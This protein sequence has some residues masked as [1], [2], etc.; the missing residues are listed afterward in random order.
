MSENK[1]ENTLKQTFKS[2]KKK[3]GSSKNFYYCQNNNNFILLELKQ[4]ENYDNQVDNIIQIYN[5]YTWLSN[6]PIVMFKHD[7]TMYFIYIKC[8]IIQEYYKNKNKNNTN[9]NNSNNFNNSNDYSNNS[10]NNYTNND[11]N[12]NH[13]HN[14]NHDNNSHNNNT[15]HN[16]NDNLHNKMVEMY[17]DALIE[18]LFLNQS[19]HTYF[20]IKDINI[21]I[22]CGINDCKNINSLIDL[23]SIDS[24]V[25]TWTYFKSYNHQSEDI[26]KKQS[27]VI[28]DGIVKEKT[29]KNKQIVNLLHYFRYFTYDLL[30]VL[31]LI[32]RGIKDD[33]FTDKVKK[34]T[35]A[36]DMDDD[37][38]ENNHNN[39]INFGPTN[40]NNSKHSNSNNSKHSNSNNSKHSNSNNSKHKYDIYDEYNA[41][42]NKSKEYI[43]ISKVNGKKNN[44][45]DYMLNFF[46]GMNNKNNSYF[47]NDPYNDKDSYK[48]SNHK[49]N[50]Y[51]YE[52]ENKSNNK[53]TYNSKKNE[54]NDEQQNYEV[55]KENLFDMF[56]SYCIEHYSR[57]NKNS[58][59]YIANTTKLNLNN[60]IEYHWLNLII[61]FKEKLQSVLKQMNNNKSMTLYNVFDNLYNF[62]IKKIDIETQISNICN[63]I[64]DYHIKN[65]SD[66]KNINFIKN[67][68]ETIEKISI[69]GVDNMI[70]EKEESQLFECYTILKLYK[71]FMYEVNTCNNNNMNCYFVNDDPNDNKIVC[72][73]KSDDVVYTNDK[74]NKQYLDNTNVSNM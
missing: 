10:Y 58:H 18:I 50:K 67:N 12:T 70:S 49:S 19:N 64:Y 35:N 32:G 74:N 56:Y 3:D 41:S 25:Y 23:D 55:I 16:N 40:K 6:R 17:C 4:G 39:Y 65:N 47:I 28:N 63:I 52:E 43:K 71:Y 20:D 73:N 46:G 44:A 38:F 68:I 51:V 1:Q 2:N 29:L 62:L 11:T 24:Y 31:E 21:G 9:S 8:N 34:N 54:S 57:N 30:K 27:Y 15:N 36:D 33:I 72:K 66:T 45:N 69:S 5:K 22:E 61:F 26:F 7:D 53:Y 13:N 60:Y 37:N 48:N 14:T 59:N 42:K